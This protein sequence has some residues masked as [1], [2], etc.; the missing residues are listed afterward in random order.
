MIVSIGCDCHVAMV[1]KNLNLRNNSSPFDWLDTK[2]ISVFE[3]FYENI[4]TDFKY[5]TFFKDL[6]VL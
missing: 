6:L 2:S 3:Y 1:L 5:S 4:T